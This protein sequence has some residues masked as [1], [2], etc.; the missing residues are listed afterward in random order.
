MRHGDTM[1][2]GVI[3]GPKGLAKLMDLKDGD[4]HFVVEWET[5]RE[6]AKD[7]REVILA[8]A[9]SRPAT[10]K[11]IMVEA[12]TLGA[13]SLLFFPSHRTDPAFERSSIWDRDRIESLLVAGCEQAFQT[14]LPIVDRLE[15]MA[16]LD[17]AIGRHSRGQAAQRW[18]LDVYEGGPHLA[19]VPYQNV[20]QV[21]A[22]GPERGWAKEDR[23]MLRSLGFELCHLGE[24]VLRVETAATISVAF[25]QNLAC[26]PSR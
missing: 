6:P 4:A 26:T 13:Q 9:I 14:D 8:T 10:M 1:W 19:R 21:I 16:A 2:V 20:V 24:R 5:S 12:A 17:G 22:I 23:K 18:A 3:N 15:S 11:K 25:A 7:R